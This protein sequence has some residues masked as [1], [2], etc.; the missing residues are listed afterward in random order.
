MEKKEKKETRQQRRE[1]IKVIQIT[2]KESH[3]AD[4]ISE[5]IHT[6]KETVAIDVIVTSKNGGRKIMVDRLLTKR[7][8]SINAAFRRLAII[9]H[10]RENF[11]S[12]STLKYLENQSTLILMS[13][14]LLKLV[15]H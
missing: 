8:G 5:S 3:L 13:S 11:S 4:R 12:T 2:I 15:Q 10:S 6:K 7:K 1:Q 14:V 9:K